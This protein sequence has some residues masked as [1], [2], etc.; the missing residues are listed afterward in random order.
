M[1]VASPCIDVCRMDADSGLCVGCLRTLD[2]IAGWGGASDDEKLDILA[3]IEKRRA[4]HDPCGAAFR[5]DCER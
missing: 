5:G 1:S 3:R 2:E 4:E